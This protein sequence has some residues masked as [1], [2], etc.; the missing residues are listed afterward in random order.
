MLN[1]SC[2]ANRLLSAGC[3]MLWAHHHQAILGVPT[4]MSFPDSQGK[5]LQSAP[6]LGIVR[7]KP[8]G[9]AAIVQEEK[10]FRSTN[11][12][13]ETFVGLSIAPPGQRERHI[14]GGFMYRDGRQDGLR[15]RGNENL[16]KCA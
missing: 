11:R 6:L 5:I 3:R 13:S 8:A 9:T 4:I 10:I 12:T 7:A 2:R 14:F 1:Q 16:W 15:R